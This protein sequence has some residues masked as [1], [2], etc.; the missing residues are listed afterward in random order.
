MNTHSFRAVICSKNVIFSQK[1]VNF[2]V[3]F[4]KKWTKCKNLRVNTWSFDEAN[5]YAPIIGWVWCESNYPEIP[6]SSKEW[7]ISYL[8]EAMHLKRFASYLKIIQIV[9]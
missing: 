8:E 7:R 3:I 5:E 1:Y 6:D 4:H 9:V 2:F